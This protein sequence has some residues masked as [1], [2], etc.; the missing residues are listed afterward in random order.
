[1]KRKWKKLLS[2]MVAACMISVVSP[3]NTLA[4]DAFT[5]SG[6]SYSNTDEGDSDSLNNDPPQ[7]QDAPPLDQDDPSLDQ[8]DFVEPSDSVDSLPDLKEN[9][10][11]PILDGEQDHSEGD[12]LSSGEGLAPGP[13][14]FDTGADLNIGDSVTAEAMLAEFDWLTSQAREM[15]A[16]YLDGLAEK[17]RSQAIEEAREALTNAQTEPAPAARLLSEAQL[18]ADNI[19]S[20]LNLELEE[21]QN[22]LGANDVLTSASDKDSVTVRYVLEEDLAAAGYQ[23]GRAHV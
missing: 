22:L 19:A 16:D 23:I 17:N 7:D 6:S 9:G 12:A 5:E 8:E 20:L 4:M 2:A 14:D 1:M 10:K 13:S 18:S 3:L 11:N 21:V 15:L